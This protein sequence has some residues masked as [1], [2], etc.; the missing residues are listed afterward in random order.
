MEVE[1]ENPNE[2]TGAIAE[3]TYF[4]LSHFTGRGQEQK[5]CGRVEREL[6]ESRG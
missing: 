2:D 3:S 6:R 4:I 5:S 1:A